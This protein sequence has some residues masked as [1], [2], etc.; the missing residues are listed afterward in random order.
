LASPNPTRAGT[1]AA[2]ETPL[3]ESI[4]ADDALLRQY[5][6]VI[7]DIKSIETNTMRLW[8]Q[9]ISMMLPDTADDDMHAEGW[10]ISQEIDRQTMD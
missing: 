8:R 2:S 6:A 10:S 1:P 3:G 7:I 4:A 9:V 5:A